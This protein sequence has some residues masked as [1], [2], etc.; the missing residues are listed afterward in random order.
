[1][2]YVLLIISITLAATKSLLS[3][4]VEKKSQHR[5]NGIVFGL[6]SIILFVVALTKG[7]TFSFD[8]LIHALVYAVFA[9]ASQLFFYNA[10][11]LGDVGVSSLVY[12]CGFII[13]TVFSVIAWSEEIGVFRI[14]GI[15]MIVLSFVLATEKKNDKG[16]FKWLVNALGGLLG[17]GAVGIVQKLYMTSPFSGELH[18]MLFEAFA[19]ASVI[20]FIL[21]FTVERKKLKEEE[22]RKRE[23]V[24]QESEGATPVDKKPLASY[25]PVVIIGLMVCAN[26]FTN[27]IN[28]VLAGA[29]PGVIFFPAVNG[30][31]I[32]LASVG[33]ILLFKEKPTPRKLI[34]IAV[35][36]V[37]IILTVL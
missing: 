4:T 20:S 16:G 10:T 12:Y 15:A 25:L 5:F 3:R 31:S 23:S 9:L 21:Y 8:T 11:R 27:L 1:M 36:V 6:G 37:A 29:L 14:I 19:F 13:P 2:E 30:G 33:G 7:L 22:S 35:G 18:I 17:S 26:A 28:G 32:L 24:E 34:S